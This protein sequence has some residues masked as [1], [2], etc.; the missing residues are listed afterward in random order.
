MTEC[1]I[2]GDGSPICR[3]QF[4]FLRKLTITDKSFCGSCGVDN[5][6]VTN[7]AVEVNWGAAPFMVSPMP[8]FLRRAGPWSGPPSEDSTNGG[9]PPLRK[10]PGG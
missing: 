7:I 3:A 6:G 8:A 5:E 2:L 10:A 9:H 1:F 4:V